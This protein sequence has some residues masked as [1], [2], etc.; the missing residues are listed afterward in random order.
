MAK[1][2]LM[3]CYSFW[4]S[5][6]QIGSHHIARNFL[7]LGYE[8][9]FL[10]SPITPLHFLQGLSSD[11]KEKYINYFNGGSRESNERLWYYV[12]CS[13]ITAQNKI[14]LKAGYRAEKFM[15]ENWWKFCFPNIL[16]KI[17][18]NGFM[19][20]DLIY[21]DNC[22]YYFLLDYIKAKK[23]IFRVVDYNSDYASST[24]TGYEFEKKVASVVDCVLYTAHS[25]KD[26]VERL[27]SN[28]TLYF[29]NGV[30]YKHFVNSNHELPPEYLKINKPIIIYVGAME[31]WFDFDLVN[32]ASEKLID[33]SFVFIGSD[34][35]ARQ[36]LII[37]NNV[38]ILGCRKYSEIPKYIWNADIGIIPF[39]VK[40]HPNLV[41]CINPLKLYEYMACGLPTIATK[42]HELELMKTPA[43]LYEN[44]DEFLIEIKK[45]SSTT[46][47][48]QKLS[49]YAANFDWNK[50]VYELETFLGI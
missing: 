30:N 43:V 47:D 21:F 19:E 27:G 5:P 26:Y 9:A 2:V 45:F 25:L 35:L 11:L 23:K 32:L 41:N 17:K 37:R 49:D 28:K 33:F 12:P 1:K 14:L 29:P 39:D 10:S 16:K 40:K 20:V 48:R 15:A 6:F 42:W 4:N 46:I 44:F 24:K 31:E 36:K 22:Y 3:A 7:D 8:V 13:L 18:E 34:K 38:H 50:K